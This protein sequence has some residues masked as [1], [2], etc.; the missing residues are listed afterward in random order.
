MSSEA[1][2]ICRAEDSSRRR[3]FRIAVGVRDLA[4]VSFGLSWLRREPRRTEDRHVEWLRYGMYGQETLLREARSRG[5]TRRG[6]G[7]ERGPHQRARESDR[8]AS[9]SFA[10]CD[11]RRKMK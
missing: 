6:R 1:V 5:R 9:Q 2:R 10:A 3:P 7:M 11:S 8:S 4:T